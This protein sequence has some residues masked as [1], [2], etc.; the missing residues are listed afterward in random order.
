MESSIEI[1][2]MNNMVKEIDV[3]LEKKEFSL[4]V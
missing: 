2:E 3:Q 1:T 4:D